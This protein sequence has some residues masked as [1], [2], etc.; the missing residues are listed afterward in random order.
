MLRAESQ[1][2]KLIVRK[3]G[4]LSFPRT[5]CALQRSEESTTKRAPVSDSKCS[6]NLAQ[7]HGA[8]RIDAIVHLRATAPASQN[9]YTFVIDE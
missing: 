5:G 8:F 2:A 4:L 7:R 3:G 9:V 1:F 6:I